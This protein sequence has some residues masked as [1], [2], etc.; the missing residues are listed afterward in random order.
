MKLSAQWRER[1][2][3]RAEGDRLYEEGD[4]LYVEGRNL[5]EEAI[6]ESYGN[7]QMEWEKRGVDYDCKLE[8]GDIYRHD[9]DVQPST[10][11]GGSNE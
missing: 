10:E 2:K 11:T 4:R 1:L 7:I 9:E 8:N 5:W 6:I 3:L